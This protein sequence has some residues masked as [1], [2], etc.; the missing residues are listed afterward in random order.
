M[1]IGP[2]YKIHVSTD[3]FEDMINIGIRPR[4]NH[5]TLGLIIK[6]SKDI[7]NRP[8]L[9]EYK[10]STSSACIPKWRSTLRNPFPVSIN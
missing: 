1:Y 8:Q 5:E 4:D 3:P 9:Q 7:G 2:P 10:N 6:Y